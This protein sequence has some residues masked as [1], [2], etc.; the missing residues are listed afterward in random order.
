MRDPNRI[1]KVL[2]ILRKNWE[3]NPD[4]RLCQLISN[5][6]PANTDGFFLEDDRL[7]EILQEGLGWGGMKKGIAKN[8]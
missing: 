8:Q 2:D 4:L 5:A 7:I 3:E 1:P 6:I